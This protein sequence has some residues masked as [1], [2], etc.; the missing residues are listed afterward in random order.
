MF[1]QLGSMVLVSQLVMQARCWMVFGVHAWTL[2]SYAACLAGMNTYNRESENT[3]CA[4][5]CWRVTAACQLSVH[6]HTVSNQWSI[7]QALIKYSIYYA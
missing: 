6:I 5:W 4:D 2:W 1:Q 3:V 7:L